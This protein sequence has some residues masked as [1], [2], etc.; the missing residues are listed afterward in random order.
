MRKNT[1]KNY[2]LKNLSETPK[3]FRFIKYSLSYVSFC[4]VWQKLCGLNKYRL[5]A[6][7]NKIMVKNSACVQM[8]SKHGNALKSNRVT[9]IFVKPH[10]VFCG[11]VD[12]GKK[13]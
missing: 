3:L 12:G 10:F 13:Y 4:D 8:F 11:S 6:F 5:F 2:Y 1:I 7:V 9:V